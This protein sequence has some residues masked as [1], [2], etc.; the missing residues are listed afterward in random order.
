MDDVR[1]VGNETSLIDCP[2]SSH[3]VCGHNEDASA[4]CRTS[5]SL[6]NCYNK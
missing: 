6:K 5:K 4:Q 3:H 1:C 2:H